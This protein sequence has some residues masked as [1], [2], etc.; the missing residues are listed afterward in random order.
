M[1]L[2]KISALKLTS[3]CKV[4]WLQT[5]VAWQQPWGSPHQVG[6]AD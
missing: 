5:P 6:F 4:V 1:R 3:F 2:C